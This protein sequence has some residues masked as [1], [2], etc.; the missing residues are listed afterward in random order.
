[1]SLVADAFQPAIVRDLFDLSGRP[2]LQ[3]VADTI[4]SAPKSGYDLDTDLT[5]NRVKVDF[6]EKTFITGAIGGDA[7]RLA[8]ACF[9]SM[10][11]IAPAIEEASSIPW[12]LIRLYYAS[13]YAGHSL[14]R[15]V[16]RSC[17]YFESQHVGRIKS[18]FVARGEPI[19]FDLPA[20][21][22]SCSLNGGQTG[23]SMIQARGRV[24]GAHETFWGIFDDFLSHSTE[25][26]LRGHLAGTDAR[27]IFAKL[28]ALRRIY[29]RSI[30]ASWLSAVRNEIQYRHGM[31]V[32]APLTINRTRRALLSRLASQWMRDPM[33]IDVDVPPSG[34]LPAFV[35]ACAFTA[36]MCRVVLVRI[37]ERSSL[38]ARSFARIPLQLCT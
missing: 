26:V 36:A 27:D 19:A 3:H 33:D 16:G 25:D 30:G 9:T 35:L 11:N 17:T 21:L 15:L 24:G 10:A 13:F 37:S 18:L 6:R 2:S 31:G 5:L 8:A 34:D 22:Y 23:F 29:R 1:M 20:G 14:L 38:P 12:G 28:E 4:T 32:W 7:A